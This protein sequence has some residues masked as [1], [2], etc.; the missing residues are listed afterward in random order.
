M[1]HQEFGLDTVL[2]W[3]TLF[4]TGRSLPVVC[5]GQLSTSWL[6]EHRVL[7]PVLF[8]QYTAELSQVISWHC[9]KFHQYADDFSPASAVQVAVD[10][11]A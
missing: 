11:F 10:Q 6:V 4:V 9:L 3:L 1:L 2:S 8:V 7:G 5:K